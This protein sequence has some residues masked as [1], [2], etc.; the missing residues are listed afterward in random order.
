MVNHLQLNRHNTPTEINE[1][2]KEEILVFFKTFY[3]MQKST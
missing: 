3:L 1:F 2:R